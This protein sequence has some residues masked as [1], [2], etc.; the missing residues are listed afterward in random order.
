[1]RFNSETGAEAGK[2]SSRKGI[3]N[4]NTKEL[5]EEIQEIIEKLT[6]LVLDD[7]KELEPD[8]RISHYIKL[9]AFVIPKF[10]HTREETSTPDVP[11]FNIDMNDWK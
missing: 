1:M 3:P 5:R 9:L 8:K 4:K 2:K 6:P 10:S 7:L 11:V